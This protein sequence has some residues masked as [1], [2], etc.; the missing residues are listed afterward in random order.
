MAMTVKGLREW[1]KD[2][3]SD[4]MIAID[5]GGR[6]LAVV[7]NTDDYIEV[8]GFPELHAGYDGDEE[9]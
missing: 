9:E 1:L 3:P 2:R 8:G 7:D 4:Q 6:A 5:D